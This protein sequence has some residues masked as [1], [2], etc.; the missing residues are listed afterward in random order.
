MKISLKE[1]RETYIWL[2]FIRRMQLYDSPDLESALEEANE[3]IAI[4]V[5][6]IETARGKVRR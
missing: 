5:R 3:L 1:L 4:F 2:K 6:S